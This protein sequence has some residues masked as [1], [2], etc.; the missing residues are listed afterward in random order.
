MDLEDDDDDIN[1]FD[2]N[3]TEAF[4]QTEN[5]KEGRKSPTKSGRSSPDKKAALGN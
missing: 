1:D 2:G 5:Q 4:K 3:A